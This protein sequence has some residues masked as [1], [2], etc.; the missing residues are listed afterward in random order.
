MGFIRNLAV[1]TAIKKALLEVNNNIESLA[2]YGEDL[3][4]TYGQYVEKYYENNPEIH[5]FRKEVSYA[6]TWEGGFALLVASHANGEMPTAGLVRS[7]NDLDV[8]NKLICEWVIRR[9]GQAINVSRFVN[10]Q[11]IR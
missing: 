7:K 10:N 5:A 4:T 9:G 3:A 11:E 1:R 2:S 6:D 8:L